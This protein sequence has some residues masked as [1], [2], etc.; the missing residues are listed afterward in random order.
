MSHLEN[1]SPAEQEKLNVKIS[2]CRRVQAEYA[3]VYDLLRKKTMYKRILLNMCKECDDVDC[4]N[5]VDCDIKTTLELL[6]A[7]Q[8][9]RG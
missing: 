7:L 4:I 5:R 6:E 2:F 3:V 8:P 9:L 1:L